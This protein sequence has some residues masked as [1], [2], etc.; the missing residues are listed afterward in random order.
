MDRAFYI[1]TPIYYVNAE[2]H[3]GHA[4]TTIVADVIKRFYVLS[5]Y[6]TFM[7]TGTDEHGQKMVRAAK[8]KGY[9]VEEYVEKMSG[10]FKELW[11]KLCIEYD[12]FIRTTYPK[13]KE[14]VKM[15]LKHVYDK[16][17][18]YFSE[19]EG[20]YCFGCE[21]FYTERELVDGKCPDHKERP[22]L[23]HES[24]YFFKM[25]RY[26]DWLVDHIE[27]NP[28][29]ITPER[30]RNE[31]LSFLKE[32]LE[33]LCISR[34]KKRLS[35]GIPLPFDEDYVTYVW[36][37]AL[38]NYI[39]ALGYPDGG[40][41][42][43]FWHYSHHLIAK[44]ILKPH[45]IYWPC[46]LRAADIPIYKQLHV[47]GYWNVQEGKMSKSLGNVVRP[48]DLISIYG[49]DPFRYFLMRE[50][51]FGRDSEFSEKALVERLNA[52]LAN[53]LGNLLSRVL[54]MA[55]KY[56]SGKDPK[57][58]SEISVKERE[59]NEQ[60]ESLIS[61][62]ERDMKEFIFH[63]ALISIWKLIG[64]LNRY[65]DEEAPWNLF[66]ENDPR[67]NT[68]MY[69]LIGGL[70]VISGLIWPFMPMSAERMQEAV[71]IVAKGKHLRLEMLKRWKDMERNPMLSEPLHLFERVRFKK[72]KA[73]K[74]EGLKKISIKEFSKID[75][76]IGKIIGADSIEGSNSLLKLKVDMGEVKTM[77]AGLARHYS[78]SELL[79]RQVVVVYNL[80][81]AEIMGVKS[82]GMIL[83]AEDRDGIC[84]LTP[85]REVSPGS[86][87]R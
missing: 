7:L 68:V 54:T 86:K 58:P 84:L 2:P 38:I 17:D 67:L 36:F 74:A 47:H 24:N 60:M 85:D 52:D 29:F 22:E 9:E 87:V 76:R 46:M 20:L 37:D 5:G 49:I 65:I 25:S 56:L 59:L 63:R 21:R 80:K 43:E 18:I 35:W 72:D 64:S 8:E 75:L 48:L 42:R 3:L 57:A 40:L 31:V 69:F 28:E 32:P 53:D 30:F 13:H 39:S 61:E 71:G 50:M 83:A 16:G 33:D 66:K 79:G 6:K 15:I 27:K 34:P 77:V 10:L 19:Y 70:R 78:P 14:T 44:D 51:V 1:T 41:F 62:Y 11:P 73:K 26:Q 4:Y 55:H 23:V 81:E 12:Y 82:E 45:A